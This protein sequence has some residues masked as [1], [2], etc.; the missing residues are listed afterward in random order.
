MQIQRGGATCPESQTLWQDQP[1]TQALVSYLS[2]AGELA[3][4]QG[5]SL[6]QRGPGA[7]GEEQAGTL[8][9]RA[10]SGEGEALLPGE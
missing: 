1:G 10:P 7:H 4:L 2:V 5:T 3:Q 8:V 9:A 6:A